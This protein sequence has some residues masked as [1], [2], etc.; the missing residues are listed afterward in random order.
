MDLEELEEVNGEL[1]E[2]MDKPI[3]NRQI[4]KEKVSALAQKMAA[5]KSMIFTDYR[6]LTAN[7]LARLRTKIKELEAE[8][9]VVKNTLLSLAL[10]K[11]KL[12]VA[13][14]QL[15]G[16]TAVIIGY[17]DEVSPVKEVAES[18][19][20]FGLPKFKFGFLGSEFLDSTQLESFAKI[21]GRNVLY[22]NVVGSL[23]SPIYGIV[24]VLNANLRNLV[25][26]LD[27][28]R[29]KKELAS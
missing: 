3:K 14:E 29:V 28:I 2:S 6:G 12:E 15:E 7:Q 22:A 20:K 25:F 4:K 21:P 26:A 19:K 8:M 1:V 10:K 5:A 23:N 16:P 27:Q 11:N 13:K 24:S 9:I 17:Q 18:A